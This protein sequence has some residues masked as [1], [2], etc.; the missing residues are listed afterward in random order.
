MNIILNDLTKK[1]ESLNGVAR[2]LN[3]RL[4]ELED[5]TDMLE[6]VNVKL[7]EGYGKASSDKQLHKRIG[8]ILNEED[9][10]YNPGLFQEKTSQKKKYAKKH[11]DKRLGRPRKTKY[12]EVYNPETDDMKTATE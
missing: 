8:S 11:P 7:T 10:P 9:A 1:I 12:K 3:C 2:F 6:K 4:N 5:R